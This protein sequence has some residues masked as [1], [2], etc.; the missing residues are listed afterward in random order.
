MKDVVAHG[1]GFAKHT[2]G[3]LHI[4]P[5]VVVADRAYCFAQRPGDLA[6]GLARQR[7]RREVGRKVV[8]Q[9]RKVAE[10]GPLQGADHVGHLADQRQVVVLWQSDARSSRHGTTLPASTNNDEHPF[11]VS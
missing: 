8:R 4:R 11:G 3:L 9:A 5:H 2:T 10:D 6:G 1:R 7:R